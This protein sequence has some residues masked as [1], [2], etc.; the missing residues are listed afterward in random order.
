LEQAAQVQLRERAVIVA[1]VTAAPAESWTRPV[2][3]TS[4]PQRVNPKASTINGKGKAE[5]LR[6]APVERNIIQRLS[7]MAID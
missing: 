1:L 4:A 7:D 3:V 5:N 2:I 6:T